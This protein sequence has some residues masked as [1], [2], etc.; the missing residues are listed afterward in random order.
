MAVIQM[1]DGD[2]SGGAE[3]RLDWGYILKVELIIFT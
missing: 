3:K 2:G 1:R